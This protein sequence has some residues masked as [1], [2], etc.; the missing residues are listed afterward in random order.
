MPPDNSIPLDAPPVKP[1]RT[2]ERRGRPRKHKNDAAR[3]KAYRHRQRLHEICTTRAK[4]L[5]AW[6]RLSS[7]KQAFILECVSL[8]QQLQTAR[9]NKNVEEIERLEEMLEYVEQ[10]E[11]QRIREERIVASR[12]PDSMSRGLYITD[13]PHGKGLL[14]F[15]VDPAAD[16]DR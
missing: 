16:S 2:P 15:V 11:R 7:A 8:T 3:S 10:M 14:V 4:A 9:I 5:A 12:K 13:A 6:N 1:K